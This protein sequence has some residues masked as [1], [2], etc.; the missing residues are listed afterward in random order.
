MAFLELENIRKTY[1][2]SPLLSGISLEVAKGELVSLLGPSGSGK[3]T[4]LRIIAGLETCEVGRVLLQGEDI[5]R[6]PT[7]RRGVILMFQEYALFPHRSVA[8]NVSFGLRMRHQSKTAIRERV[9][10]MLALV[11][12]TG[13]GDR[14]VIELSGGER[15]R[16][17]LARSLAPEPRLLLLDEPVGSLDRNLRERLLEE[18][19]AILRKVGVTAIAVTHD[20]AEAFALADRVALLHDTRIVQEGRP[21]TIYRYPATPWVAR[22]LGLT[23]LM[24]AEIVGKTQLATPLGYLT[25]AADNGFDGIGS[26]GTLLILPWGIQ[27]TERDP[28]CNGFTA[29]VVRR[30]FQGRTTKLRLAI[31]GEMLDTTV[32][33][34][35][36]IPEEDDAVRV[37]IRP[38]ALRW[39]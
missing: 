19:A 34:G 8:E 38:E 35:S 25:Y 33:V 1:E 30:M 26:S 39:F 23:N 28:P 2:G 16:V 22:F 11:S 3:T 4:L 14:N 37:W 5:S 27:I 24:Q 20:Q 18:L 15:Q 9:A 32:D 36:V 29:R 21:E 31:E 17:A 7:H 13:F 6:L 10:E 12:L